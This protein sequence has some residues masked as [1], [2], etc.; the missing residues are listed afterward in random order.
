MSFRDTIILP[1]CYLN[2]YVNIF[3]I[4]NEI[5]KIIIRLFI[6]IDFNPIYIDYC[7]DIPT[8]NVI[9]LYNSCL[10]EWLFFIY[11]KYTKKK[12]IENICHCSSDSCCNYFYNDTKHICGE[13]GLIHCIE[14]MKY[15]KEYDI[16]EE[17]IDSDNICIWCYHNPDP[18]FYD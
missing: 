5:I 11:N 13:C 3:A 10:Q 18:D 7:K 1:I 12:G 4:P 16:N 8:I 14:C 9:T 15:Y 6:V 17:L 2:E